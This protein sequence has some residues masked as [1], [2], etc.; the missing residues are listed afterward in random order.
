MRPKHV[1][2]SANKYSAATTQ[3][4]AAEERR[5]AQL[6]AAEAKKREAEEKRAAQVSTLQQVAG[7]DSIPGE[8]K[9]SCFQ[10][11]SCKMVGHK[12]LEDTL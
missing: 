12:P 2:Q 9:M 4:K 5:R 8:L 7:M 10:P 3:A 11:A 6:E 1:T